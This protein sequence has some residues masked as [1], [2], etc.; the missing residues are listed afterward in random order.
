MRAYVCFR[1]NASVAPDMHERDIIAGKD[2]ANEQAAV[3]IGWV[4]F[5]AHDG[6][7][8]YLAILFEAGDSLA[9][10]RCLGDAVVEDVSIR[11]VERISLGAATQ[12][13]T[14]VA[15]L[16]ASPLNRVFHLWVVEVGDVARERMGSNIYEDLYSV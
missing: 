10:E 15:V 1:L 11:V 3:A 5:A 14:H 13:L 12:F 7:A 4:F 8:I 9:K 6:N 2:P 16:N